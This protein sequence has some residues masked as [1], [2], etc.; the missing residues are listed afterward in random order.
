MEQ[1]PSC[2]NFDN[3]ELLILINKLLLLSE[4]DSLNYTDK[5]SE[6]LKGEGYSA[7]INVIRELSRI[8]FRKI[9]FGN[10]KAKLE[11]IAHEH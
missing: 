1:M 10:F 11:E 8:N 3:E 5:V 9:S 6:F 2:K 7:D 4:K